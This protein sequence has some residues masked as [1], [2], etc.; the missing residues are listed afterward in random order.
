MSVTRTA[1]LELAD[2]GIVVIRIR[3]DVDQAV[4]DAEANI[5]AARALS[6]GRAPLLVDLRSARP[7]SPETRHHYSGRVLVEAFTALALLVPIGPFGRMFG[8]V[9]LRVARPGIP[10]QVFAEEGAALSW[11]AGHRS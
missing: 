3:P 5:A 2:P 9:Y 10:T 4:S 7:L 1:R 11:L 6:G 8:N